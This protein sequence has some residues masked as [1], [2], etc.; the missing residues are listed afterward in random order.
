MFSGAGKFCLAHWLR[1]LT[2]DI[3]Y[4]VR[5]LNF[6]R[7]VTFAP[8]QKNTEWHSEKVVMRRKM[9]EMKEMT[10]SK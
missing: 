5:T 7:D 1:Q 2:R 10:D 8:L 6:R 4:D 3:K 9:S